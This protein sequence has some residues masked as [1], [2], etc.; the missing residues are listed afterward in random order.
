MGVLVMEVFE[1]KCVLA[2]G[3]M[4]LVIAAIRRKDDSKM[5]LGDRTVSRVRCSSYTQHQ[6]VSQPHLDLRKSP[7]AVYFPSG[8]YCQGA[9]EPSLANISA[10]ICST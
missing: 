5:A 7:H 2:N 1:Y 6:Q 9:H 8:Y 4:V 3:D 10:C